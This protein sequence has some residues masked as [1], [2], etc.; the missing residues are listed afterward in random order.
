M[1]KC[2]EQP[3]IE[4]RAIVTD[5]IMLSLTDYT[6]GVAESSNVIIED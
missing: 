5:Q 3:I 2:F 1:K 6:W 4:V